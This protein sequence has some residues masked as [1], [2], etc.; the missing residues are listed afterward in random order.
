MNTRYLTLVLL[1]VGLAGAS[2]LSF[3]ATELRG[4]KVVI[5]ARMVAERLGESADDEDLIRYRM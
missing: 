4:R 3:Q 2:Q 1:A 5:D